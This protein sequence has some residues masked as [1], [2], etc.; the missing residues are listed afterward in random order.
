MDELISVQKMDYNLLLMNHL[1]R[2]SF[3]STSSFIQS[4]SKD[5][6]DTHINPPKAGETAMTWGVLYLMNIIPNDLKDTKYFQ[7]N[8]EIHKGKKRPEGVQL[9]FAHLRACIN[10]LHRKGLLISS[11]S[12]GRKKKDSEEWQ[13]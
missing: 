5:A 1:N 12:S 2:L 13:E 3:V 8:E 4:V 7:E 11:F 6:K 10:L 9:N